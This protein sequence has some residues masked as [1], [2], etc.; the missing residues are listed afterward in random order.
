[1]FLVSTP[2]ELEGCD[3]VILLLKLCVHQFESLQDMRNFGFHIKIY[4]QKFRLH[5]SL[6]LLMEVILGHK[7][8]ISL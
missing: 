4:D 5:L 7:G 1:M 6:S 2:G 8:I 3:T